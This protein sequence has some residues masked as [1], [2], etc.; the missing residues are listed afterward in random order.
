LHAGL[1]AQPRSAPLFEAL[2]DR[3]NRRV[4]VGVVQGPVSILQND[5][6]R[7]ALFFI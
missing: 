6:E 7:K 4:G 2:D 3:A 1:S 5:P